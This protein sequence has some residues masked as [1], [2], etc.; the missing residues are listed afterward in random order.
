MPPESTVAFEA[1]P[2]E[3]TISW[4]PVE[5]VVPTADPLSS[6]NPP[7]STVPLTVPPDCT[8]SVPPN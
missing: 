4:L 8:I 7:F 6:S 2:P 3:K 5:I 1:I